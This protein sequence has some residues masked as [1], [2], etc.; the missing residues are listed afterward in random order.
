MQF[1]LYWHFTEQLNNCVSSCFQYDGWVYWSGEAKNDLKKPV[2]AS[3]C[4][5]PNLRLLQV[6]KTVKGQQLKQ[7]MDCCWSQL[8][9]SFIVIPFPACPTFSVDVCKRPPW[10]L[11]L[12]LLY[13]GIITPLPIGTCLSWNNKNILRILA[14]LRWLLNLQGSNTFPSGLRISS[15]DLLSSNSH[16]RTSESSVEDCRIFTNMLHHSVVDLVFKFWPWAE[17]WLREK[18]VYW[19]YDFIRCSI[20]NG[21]KEGD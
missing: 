17:L 20:L 2:F 19:S 13:W 21:G 1:P 7:R 10:V 4:A 11:R 14:I 12:V 15:L 5:I 16:L 3:L 8:G 18:F 6:T 9:W